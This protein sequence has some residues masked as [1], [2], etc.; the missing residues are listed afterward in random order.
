MDQWIVYILLLSLNSCLNM[1]YTVHEMDKVMC[2]LCC[3]LDFA[4]DMK[5]RPKMTNNKKGYCYKL[6][7]I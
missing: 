6:M 7:C 5:I 1:E 3:N 4:H 2:I